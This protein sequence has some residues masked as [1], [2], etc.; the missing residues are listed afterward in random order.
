MKSTGEASDTQD[1]P[2]PELVEL[3]YSLK[4]DWKL[5]DLILLSSIKYNDKGDT[6]DDV[7]HQRQGQLEARAAWN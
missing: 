2:D 4:L 5:E 6:F 3:S 1:D 7:S